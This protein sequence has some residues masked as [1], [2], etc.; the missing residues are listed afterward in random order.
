MCTQ[1]F[2]R[3]RHCWFNYRGFRLGVF[4]FL[5]GENEG[6]YWEEEAAQMR[7]GVTGQEAWGF[8]HSP[9]HF[10]PFLAYSKGPKG[11]TLKGSPCSFFSAHAH[12]F[13]LVL[14]PRNTGRRSE[15]EG[16]C[17]SSQRKTF[18]LISSAEMLWKSLFLHDTSRAVHTAWASPLLLPGGEKLRT[19][20]KRFF[21]SASL[22][23][24]E[25]FISNFSIFLLFFFF[26]L[27]ETSNER[28]TLS[29]FCL[30]IFGDGGSLNLTN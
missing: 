20:E 13:S 22:L 12:T 6:V 9:P 23:Q 28:T 18:F 19:W 5:S 24:N 1:G 29:L 26:F 17:N 16:Q 4:F 10:Y 27:N 14:H 3:Y 7:A 8:P 25:H 21:Y 15:E 30:N 2:S 11:N